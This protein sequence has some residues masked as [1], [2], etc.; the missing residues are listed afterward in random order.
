MSEAFD[1]IC[2]LQR[3]PV[4][5]FNLLPRFPLSSCSCSVKPSSRNGLKTLSFGLLPNLAWWCYWVSGLLLSLPLNTPIQSYLLCWRCTDPVS[6]ISPLQQE[7]RKG[8]RRNAAQ[9][10][11]ENEVAMVMRDC[12]KGVGKGG[13]WARKQWE[14]NINE[15]PS[16]SGTGHSENRE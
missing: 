15:W 6:S 5:I 12:E 7:L 3:I 9:Q 10:K 8:R 13:R 14:W 1:L 16:F 11:V 4:F 2:A